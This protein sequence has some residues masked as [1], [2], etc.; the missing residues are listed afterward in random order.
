MYDEQL[1]TQV[2]DHESPITER[3]RRLRGA[4]NELTLRNENRRYASTAGIS[5]CNRGLGF[6]P[7]YL[8]RATGELSLS[9]F[10]D[11]RAAP[12]HLLDGLPESWVEQRDEHGHVTV[13]DPDVVSGFIR[14]GRFYTREQA[15]RAKAH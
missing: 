15:A 7:G 2:F 5:Q 3:E 4:L 11:G 6:R 14:D 12:I 13:I 1:Q 10:D 9:R 8:N